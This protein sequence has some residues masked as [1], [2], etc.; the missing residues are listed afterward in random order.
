MSR[1]HAV[2]PLCQTT[3]AI[4]PARLHHNPVCAKC[5]AS[6]LPAQPIEL[7]DHT[8]DRYIH[9]STL[10]VVVDFWA[11]WCGPCKMMAPVFARAAATLHGQILLA[12]INTETCPATAGRLTIQSIPTLILFRQG[13]EKARTAGAM[14]EAQLVAWVRSQL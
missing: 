9:R 7:T 5:Q 6:L 14:Q 1:L 10:P 2:C 8:F 13:V 3:N 11:S 12:K 4:D